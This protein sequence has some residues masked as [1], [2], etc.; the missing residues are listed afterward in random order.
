MFRRLA[1]ALLIFIPFFGAAQDSTSY[2]IGTSINYHP[3]DLF[4]HIRGQM[5]KK[6]FRQDVFLGF[7]IIKTIFQSQFRPSLGTDLAY[8]FKLNTRFSVSPFIR[9][10]YSN[11][12]IKIPSKHPFIHTT[13][14]FLAGRIAFGKK[15]KIAIS[16]GIGPAI[17]WK[18]DAYY[19]RNQHFFMWNYFAEIAYYYE[20]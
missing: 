11:L 12:N 15:N 20:F 8:E 7:G 13:E 18:Y 17:E 10:A 14:C 19:E 2:S 6:H 16:G 3:Q 1:L 9:L 5:T 4:F